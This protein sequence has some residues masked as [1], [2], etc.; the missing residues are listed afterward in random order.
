MLF[1]PMRWPFHLD[2]DFDMPRKKKERRDGRE[3]EQK[4]IVKQLKSHRGRHRAA[5][6]RAGEQLIDLGSKS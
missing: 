2:T 3:I 6:D 4:E 1:G 5:V